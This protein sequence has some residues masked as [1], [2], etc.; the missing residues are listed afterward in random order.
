MMVA[1][2]ASETTVDNYFTRQ[3]IP[4]YNYEINFN[5]YTLR[6]YIEDPHFCGNVLYPLSV[7]RNSVVCPQEPLLKSGV[8]W[9][10]W[11]YVTLP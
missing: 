1:V 5:Q 11:G 6:I 7:I 9:V 2:R 4:E 10:K 8:P 3:Y